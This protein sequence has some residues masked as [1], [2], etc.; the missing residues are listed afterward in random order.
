MKN[1]WLV[2]LLILSG[3]ALQDDSGLKLVSIHSWIQGE[4]GCVADIELSYKLSDAVIDALENGVPLVFIM[5]LR[6]MEKDASWLDEEIVS[7]HVFRVRY[8]PLST[9]YEVDLF[10]GDSTERKQFVTQD[11]LFAYLSELKELHVI[12][13]AMLKDDGEYEII[14][15]IRL[16]IESLPLPMRPRAYLSSAWNQNSGW[17][18]WPLNH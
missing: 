13:R 14:A 15:S 6:V 12:D 16:D 7:E 9:L 4:Q 1:M 3:C 5:K 17:S 2:L 10:S 11:A 18:R 8:R